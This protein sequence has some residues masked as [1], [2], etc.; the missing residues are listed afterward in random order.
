MNFNF[1]Y[2]KVYKCVYYINRFA[3]VA[4]RIDKTKASHP[5][6]QQSSKRTL[7]GG[8]NM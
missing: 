3:S 8:K 5:L 1:V 6:S 7:E 4:F 2:N